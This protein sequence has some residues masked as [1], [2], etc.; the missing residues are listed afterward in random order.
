MSAITFEPGDMLESKYPFVMAF[1][2]L[3][4]NQ[5]EVTNY[6]ERRAPDL[7]RMAYLIELAFAE[8]S[9]ELYTLLKIYTKADEEE[10]AA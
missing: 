10:N 5:N 2:R 9:L 8:A 6:L 4:R 7:D 1:G 3:A